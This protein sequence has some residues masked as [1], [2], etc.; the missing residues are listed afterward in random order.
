MV[1]GVVEI[2]FTTVYLREKKETFPSFVATCFYFLIFSHLGPETQTF[3]IW[4]V[5]NEDPLLILRLHSLH[6]FK[7]KNL[8]K[9][10]V[11]D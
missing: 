5:S 2:S 6:V 3:K 9:P 4:G 1:V 10:L 7:K 8:I 11:C